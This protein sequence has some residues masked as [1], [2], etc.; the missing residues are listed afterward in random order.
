MVD[1]IDLRQ[2]DRFELFDGS[3]GEILEFFDAEPRRRHVHAIVKTPD[4]NKAILIV[5]D[6]QYWKHPAGTTAEDGR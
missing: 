2:G 5:Y 4:G 6:R 3:I 1:G